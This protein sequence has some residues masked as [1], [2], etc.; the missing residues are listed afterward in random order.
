MMNERCICN[1]HVK[2]GIACQRCDRWFHVACSG[3]SITRFNFYQKPEN[4]NSKWHCISCLD[5]LLTR[6]EKLENERTT[7]DIETRMLSLERK[8]EETSN[9]NI[10]HQTEIL[11]LFVEA[12]NKVLDKIALVSS[13]IP[14]IIASQSSTQEAQKI[15]MSSVFKIAELQSTQYKKCHDNIVTTK[16]LADVVDHFN[17]AQIEPLRLEANVTD[18]LESRTKRSKNILLLNVTEPVADTSYKRRNIDT[19]MAHKLI[20][21]LNTGTPTNIKRVHRIGQWDKH[22]AAGSKIRPLL[23]E[24]K[25]TSQRD[26]VLQNA[27]KLSTCGNIRITA[28]YTN[29]QRAIVSTWPAIHKEGSIANIIRPAK[30][31]H[32]PQTNIVR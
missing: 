25:N 1:K 4:R 24:L 10:N 31:L 8:L 26:M 21:Q 6:L 3:L 23:V 29:S 27:Y 12:Q 15:L 16:A 9:T 20:H 17:N 14:N 13:I 7:G 2:T 5:I 18:E 22:R 11:N 28:D 19:E 32:R 30:N